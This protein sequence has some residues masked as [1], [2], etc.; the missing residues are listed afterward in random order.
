M[1]LDLAVIIYREVWVGDIT[2]AEE[3]LPQAE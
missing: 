1:S 2:F 3:V